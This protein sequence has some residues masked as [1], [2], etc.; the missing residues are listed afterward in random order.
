MATSTPTES[1]FDD[2]SRRGQDPVLGRRSASLEFDISNGDRHDRWLVVVKKG[3]VSVTPGG[4]DADGVLHADRALFDEL[5]EGRRSSMAALLRG[6][7]QAEG[8][9]AALSLVLRLV[10]LPAVAPVRGNPRRRG[11]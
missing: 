8:D 11:D 5:V 3:A 1:F 4:G 9:L 10:P 7:V 2:L 6:A